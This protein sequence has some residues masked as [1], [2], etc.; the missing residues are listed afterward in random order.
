MT[1]TTTTAPAISAAAAAVN[2]PA[3]Y[4]LRRPTVVDARAAIERVYGGA[5]ADRV[6]SQVAGP[7]LGASRTALTVE[8]IV[9]AMVASSD[10]V[11]R[12]CGQALLIR[13]RSHAH[14]A[15]ASAIVG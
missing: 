9:D 6:W 1:T 3:A 10:D 5:E 8:E 4:G 11:V 14:L 12:L 13:L 15:A 2:R 7:A